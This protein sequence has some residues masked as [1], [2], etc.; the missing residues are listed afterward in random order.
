MKKIKA[1]IIDDEALARGLIKAFLK[2]FSEIEVSAECTD[3]F[4]GIKAIRELNPQVIFLDI[5]M[6]KLTGFEMLEL[7]EHTPLVIFTTAYDQ[8]ALKAFENNA[9]DYLLKPFSK[10]RFAKSVKKAL[11]NISSQAEEAE[12]IRK[13]IQSVKSDTVLER[14]V[15]K[16]GTKV[17][18]IP[19]DEIFFLEAQDDYV[20][21]YTEEGKFL[22]QE[23]MKFFEAHLGNSFLR[24]HRS[25]IVNISKI[26]HVEAYEKELHRI[27]LLNKQ[28]IPVSRSGYTRLKEQLRF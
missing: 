17:K 20:M 28:P 11:E 2:D 23:T 5:Q 1:L 10:E 25:F 22:K 13:I 24:V 19:V 6:P 3:G 4:S 9:T 26:V 15:V 27:I 18:I 12:K 8:Y 16:N 14:V 21:I 7:L